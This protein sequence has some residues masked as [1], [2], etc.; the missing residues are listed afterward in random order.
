MMLYSPDRI[1]ISMY[2]HLLM[3]PEKNYLFYLAY[4]SFIEDNYGLVQYLPER[5]ISLVTAIN[6]RISMFENIVNGFKGCSD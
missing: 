2:F 5:H 4:Y 3:N 6:R 1:P